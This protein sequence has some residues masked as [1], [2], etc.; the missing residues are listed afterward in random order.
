MK[1]DA[2]G[3]GTW[4]TEGSGTSLSA[5]YTVTNSQTDRTFD[6]NNTTINE[7]ADVL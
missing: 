7:L 4:E 5:N 6:A 1:S 3:N 2:N